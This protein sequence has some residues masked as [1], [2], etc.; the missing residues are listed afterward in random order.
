M[1]PAAITGTGATASTT[2]GTSGNVAT[3]PHTCPSA[4]QPCATTTSAP[5]ATARR[6][7]AALPTMYR[8]IPPASW[9][10]LM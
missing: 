1:P 2:A 8:T 7:L 10:A 9:T 4:S 6:A 5:D 3:V